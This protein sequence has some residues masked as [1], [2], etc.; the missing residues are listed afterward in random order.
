VI[1]RDGKGSGKKKNNSIIEWAQ[2][3]SKTNKGTATIPKYFPTLV[4]LTIGDAMTIIT[5]HALKQEKNSITLSF[6]SGKISLRNF[7]HLPNPKN[8]E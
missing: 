5:H 8:P 1:L 6:A 7:F 4:T 2:K 3:S